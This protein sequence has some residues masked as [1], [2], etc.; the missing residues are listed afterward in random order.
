MFA[1]VY[2]NQNISNWDVNNV[3]IM[4]HMFS[5]GRKENGIIN[6]KQKNIPVLRANAE[7]YPTS[8]NQDI[9][10]WGVSNVENMS[11][12]FNG[13][14]SLIRILYWNVSNVVDMSGMFL[15]ANLLIKISAIGMCLV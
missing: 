9:S 1:G 2:L 11:G 6:G 8:F 4:L 3:E 7:N 14:T 5:S 10:K 12:M 15:D 13:A